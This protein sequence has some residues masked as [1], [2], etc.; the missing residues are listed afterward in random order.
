M[1]INAQSNLTVTTTATI[2]SEFLFTIFATPL[3]IDA[4]TS[5]EYYCRSP[6]Y[7]RPLRMIR[8]VIHAR[9]VSNLVSNISHMLLLGYANTY[10]LIAACIAVV[11]YLGPALLFV[12][13]PTAPR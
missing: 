10:A 1:D 9:T 2:V 7:Y 11:S 4:Y 5:E 3:A 13:R 8:P 12:G 6:P